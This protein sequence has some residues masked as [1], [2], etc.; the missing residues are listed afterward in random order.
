MAT[1]KL[2]YG[3]TTESY[4]NSSSK[5]TTPSGILTKGSSTV[6]IP[7]LSGS[8]GTTAVLGDYF[9]TLGHLSL[10]DGYCPISR[11]LTVANVTIK[12]YYYY[13]HDRST[14]RYVYQS[15]GGGL[16]NWYCE[17]HIYAKLEITA[18]SERCSLSAIKYTP[19]NGDAATTIKTNLTTYQSFY[20]KEVFA[21]TTSTYQSAPETL[22][23]PQT[24]DLQGVFKVTIKAK[25]GFTLSATTNTSSKK[26]SS[27]SEQ[28]YSFTVT[29]TKT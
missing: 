25:S 27:A 15:S 28:N 24:S 23:T 10:G 14:L 7:I 29:G 1:L 12:V 19:S 18:G 13:A 3:S 2:N 26:T 17:F 4:W 9:Y 11:Y 22:S 20:T 5:I 21:G 6:Y 16:W 8:P